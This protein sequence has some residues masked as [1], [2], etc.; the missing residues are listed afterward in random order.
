MPASRITAVDAAP[1]M[2]DFCRQRWPGDS[3]GRFILADAHSFYDQGAFDLI[4]ASCSLQWFGDR[5][6]VIGRM[7]GMLSPGGVV[8]LAVPV[9]G[10]LA[11]LAESYR[12]MVGAAMPGLGWWEAARY[13]DLMNAAGLPPTYTSVESVRVR[14]D[15]PLDVLRA[16][17]AIGA[18]FAGRPDWRPLPAGTVRRMLA[19]YRKRF[20]DVRGR[21]SSTY[22]V[23]YMVNEVT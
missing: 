23:L 21:V 11:E 17:K 22:R 10:T 1:G 2:V 5:A 6:R 19:H 18:T 3:L 16:I 4:A 13:I 7:R 20:G 15:E 14:Y 12:A 9:S 8:L